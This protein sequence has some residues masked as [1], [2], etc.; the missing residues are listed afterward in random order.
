MTSRTLT[1]VMILHLV[2]AAFGTT[3][4]FMGLAFA[5]YMQAAVLLQGEQVLA[6]QVT[7]TPRIEIRTHDVAI[8][9]SRDQLVSLDP[10][11]HYETFA[12]LAAEVG[13]GVTK[14]III[15]LGEQMA[16]LLEDGQPVRMYQVSTGKATTPTPMGDFQVHRKQELRISSQAVPYRMP[17]YLSFTPNGAYGLHALPYLGHSPDSSNYWHEALDHIGTPV[18]HGCIRFLPDEARALYN[19][20]EVGTPVYVRYQ[21]ALRKHVKTVVTLP[22]DQVAKKL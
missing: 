9:Q 2:A 20:A 1:P 21:T 18:S 10:V 15:D 19:W 6:K 8:A 3:S 4:A 14:E 13:T 12:P 22:V 7:P 5:T 16:F 11:L 17:Y